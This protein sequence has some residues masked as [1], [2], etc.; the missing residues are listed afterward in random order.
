[1]TGLMKEWTNKAWKKGSKGRRREGRK[2]GKTKERR[3]E[4]TGIRGKTGNGKL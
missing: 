4:K 2:E 3:G 1:M